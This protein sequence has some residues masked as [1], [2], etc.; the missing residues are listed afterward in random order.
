MKYRLI[1]VLAIIGFA[2]SLGFVVGNRLAEEALGVALAVSIGVVVGVPV[3]VVTAMVWLRI[4][5]PRRRP[6]TS[7]PGEILGQSAHKTPREFDLVG[8][9]DL[10]MDENEYEP[11][12]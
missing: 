11:P 1:I 5:S 4:Y 10:I 12:Q 7:P 8:G 6:T 3:G 9:A 2:V